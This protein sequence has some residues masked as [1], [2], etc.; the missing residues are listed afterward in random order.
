MLI[1]LLRTHVVS[2]CFVNCI[3]FF[4]TVPVF[5]TQLCLT[6][7]YVTFVTLHCLMLH[8][9]FT[10]GCF[11]EHR[12]AIGLHCVILDSTVLFTVGLFG[13]AGPWFSDLCCVTLFWF[14]L[15]YLS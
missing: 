5:V 4:C 2:V 11:V 10:S 3:E 12:P 8:S 15:R 7:R 14:V 1:M 13:V 6:L 9:F